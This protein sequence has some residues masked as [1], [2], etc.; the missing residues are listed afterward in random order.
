MFPSRFVRLDEA[1]RR[2]GPRVDRLGSFL[3]AG[4][5]LA[6][7]AV[8]AL[9]GTTSEERERLVDRA[10]GGEGRAL[11]GE[12]RALR[13]S[14]SALPF[15]A[16]LER[17]RRGGEVLLRTGFFGGVVLGFRSLIAGYCSPAGNKPLVF[18]GRLREAAPR[19]LSETSRFVSLVYQ[20][21]S[22]APGAPGWVAAARVRL[23]HAQIRR[24]LRASPRWDARAWGDPI[25][26]VDMAGTVLLFS[27][28]L[29][30][31]LRM[32]GFRISR[33]ECEDVLHL[34]RIGGWVLGVEHEL[35][36]ATEPEA[37]VLWELLE[38][39]QEPPDADSGELAAALLESPLHE[40]RS[41]EERAHAERFLPLAY[42][43]GRYLVG[44]RYADA[45]GYP[46]T[47]WR[48]VAPALRTLISGTGRVL[49]RLPGIDRLALEAGLRYWRRTVE[50]GLAGEDARFEIP[51]RVS[52]A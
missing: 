37:R 46:R 16:D 18:S 17:A 19:R 51:A 21:G 33:E 50:L 35:L 45:L 14:L 39:T 43:I 10:L 11:P 15:W 36:A 9:A 41:A 3:G 52:Q 22:L 40:A 49:G 8:E 25:N 26:Q 29:V 6:D 28:V 20:P 44:E 31:G 12:L 34:W 30:D 24:L 1:R 38:A 2:F 7:A 48:L 42:G 32:L 13:E 4:D 23:M 27:L 47:P 5:P